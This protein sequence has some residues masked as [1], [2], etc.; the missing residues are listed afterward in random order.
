MEIQLP[1]TCLKLLNVIW[2]ERKVLMT[3]QVYDQL[4]LNNFHQGGLPNMY[5]CAEKKILFLHV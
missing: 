3:H 1:Q 5:H 2:L 4:A